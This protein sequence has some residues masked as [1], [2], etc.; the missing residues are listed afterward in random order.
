M[1]QETTLY[2][3]VH[4]KVTTNRVS[5]PDKTYALANVA[6]VEVTKQDPDTFWS[7]VIILVGA[8]GLLVGVATWVTGNSGPI[9]A[10]ICAVIL[11]LGILF[12]RTMAKNVIYSVTL[13]SASGEAQAMSG[14]DEGY[15]RHVADAISEAIV[16]RG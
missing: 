7:L 2:E 1:S 11:A 6:S 9:G 14:R 5:F 3:D 16:A 13:S 15:I 12:Y 4:V 10:G 8:F